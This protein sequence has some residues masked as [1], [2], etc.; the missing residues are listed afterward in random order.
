MQRSPEALVERLRN[1]KGRIIRY[2]VL[3]L[4]CLGLCGMYWF[5]F[6]RAYAQLIPK[7][8]EDLVI[9]AA[10]SQYIILPQIVYFQIMTILTGAFFGIFTMMV[11]TEITTFTKNDLLVQLWDHV[12][13]LEQ[14]R[15]TNP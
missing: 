12:Q 2:S 1:R 8:G 9:H 14:N 10:I 7:E 11:L 4:I 5:L 6:I 13:V 15:S 3:A